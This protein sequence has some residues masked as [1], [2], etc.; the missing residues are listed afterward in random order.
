MF[1][2]RILQ[3]Q[4]EVVLQRPNI[5]GERTSSVVV[6]LSP[7]DVGQTTKEQVE[8]QGNTCYASLEKVCDTLAKMFVFC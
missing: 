5:R 8:D 2:V 7:H 3:V 6:M 1:L 4:L